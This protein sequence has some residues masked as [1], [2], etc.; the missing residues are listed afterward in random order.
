M[1][2][3]QMKFLH[4]LSTDSFKDSALTVSLGRCIF[5]E[6]LNDQQQNNKNQRLAV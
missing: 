5:D 2:N 6:S 1:K 3:M 4:S